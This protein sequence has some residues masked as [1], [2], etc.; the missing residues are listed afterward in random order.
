MTEELLLPTK[1]SKPTKTVPSSMIIFGLPKC[2]KTTALSKLDDCL[3]IDVEKGADFVE[4][5]RLQPPKDFGPVATFKWIKQVAKKIKE[6][7]R[8]YKFV[9]IETLSH[10]DE[11]SEW[12]GT[13]NYMNSPQGKSF[14]RVKDKNG[15]PIKSGDFIMPDDP[16]YQSVYTLPD[17]NGYRWS[18]EV[19]TDIFDVCKDLGSICTIFVCHVT[20]KYVVSKQSNTEVKA[21]DLALTGKVRNIL[22]RDA[23]AIGYV[24]NKGGELFISFKGDEDKLGGMRGNS[25]MQGYEGKLD[26]NLIFPQD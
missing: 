3:N 15:V 25:H 23:D 11:L 24:Y 16:E 6:E 26:W 7:G 9:A 5:L 17:G 12:V 14:N 1:P 19:M 21:L 22:P 18:R 20:D 4:T 8:P 10:L 13:F 2:G